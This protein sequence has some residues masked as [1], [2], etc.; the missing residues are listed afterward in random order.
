MVP[1]NGDEVTPE[2]RLWLR[3]A[4]CIAVD[5]DTV[6]RP[7]PALCASC[8]GRWPCMTVQL[9]DALDVNEARLRELEAMLG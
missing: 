9:L 5:S 4:H 2:Y 6:T 7:A 8:G 3:E 1:R